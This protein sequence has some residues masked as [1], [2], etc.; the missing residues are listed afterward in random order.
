MQNQDDKHEEKTKKDP[1]IDELDARR[2][3]QLRSYGV[4]KSIHH[5]HSCY[6]DRYTGLEMLPAKI[7]SGLKI[8]NYNYYIVKSGIFTQTWAIIIR[9]SE[10]K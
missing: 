7:Q 1:N 6:R 3:R 2:L 5:K 4:V 8:E 10:G 9:K